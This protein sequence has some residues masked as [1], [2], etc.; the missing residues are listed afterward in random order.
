M[1]NS[2]TRAPKKARVYAKNPKPITKAK[3]KAKTK[4]KKIPLGS[5][6]RS[7]MSKLRLSDLK[8]ASG[9]TQ[10]FFRYMKENGLKQEEAPNLTSFIRAFFQERGARGVSGKVDR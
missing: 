4:G 3:V 1:L 7:W 2:E 6:V 9:V 10:L 8:K 5:P